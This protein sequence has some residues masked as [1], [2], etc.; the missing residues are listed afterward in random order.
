VTDHLIAIGGK[1][2]R[3]AR[4]N[5]RRAIHR[6]S[7]YRR[8]ATLVPGPV[9]TATHSNQIIAIPA[10]RD[11]LLLK[12]AIVTIAAMGWQSEIAQK[13]ID[14]T[15]SLPQQLAARNVQGQSR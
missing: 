11:A 5:G 15:A 4:C 10:L 8:S 6:V 12:G 1:T 2:V 9:K 13:I 14:R 7:T 3:D